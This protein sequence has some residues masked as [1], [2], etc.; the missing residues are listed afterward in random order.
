MHRVILKSLMRLAVTEVRN[1]SLR[2]GVLRRSQSIAPFGV[3]S[4]IDLPNESIMPLSIDFWP[5]NMGVLIYDERLQRRLGV[6]YFKMIPSQ[7]EMPDGGVPCVRFPKWLFCPKCRSFKPINVWIDRYKDKYHEI[8]YIPECDVCRV[9][10]V[11]SRFIVAC[12]KGHIDDFPWVTWAHKGDLCSNPDLEIRTGGI[13]SGLTGIR[14][15]C[16]SCGAHNNM[17]G[18]FSEDA[19]IKCSGY[20]PW[21]GKHE[22]CDAVPRTLQ[23]GAS[24]TYFAQVINSIVIPQYTDSIYQKIKETS[25]WRYLVEQEGLDESQTKLIVEIIAKEIGSDVEEVSIAVDKL[26]KSNSDERSDHSEIDYRYDEYRAFQGLLG[27]DESV[28]SDFELEVIDGNNYQIHGIESITLVHRLREVRA[29]VAFSRIH[30]LDRHEI[31][32]EDKENGSAYAVSVRGKRV[33]DWLPAVEVRGEG[34]FIQFAQDKLK[35]WESDSGVTKRTEVLNSRYNQMAEERGFSPRVIT[36]RFIFLHTLA[37]LLIRQLSFECGYGSASL[38][39]RIYCNES[40]DQ[41]NMAGILIY[42][43]SGDADGTL[44]GLVRQGKPDFFSALVSKAVASGYWCSSDPLCIE[45]QGQGLGSLNLAA[46]HACALLPETSCEEFNRL[47]D[48][49]LVVGLPDDPKIGFLSCMLSV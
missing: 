29:L 44:G 24:N 49:T 21:L 2:Y 39:E 10:L 26:L 25:V 36:P 35:S 3:G 20:M 38:R 30:P 33:R 37:H 40:A 23:R 46:C 7:E 12:E 9:K 11:P 13:S 17:A 45:S 43:A 14:V 42:T 41:P 19:H 4:I 34:I 1:R 22:K 28:T 31:P 6:S 16:K 5:K 48:R 8:F 15:L 27:R 32:D 18:A 47:L